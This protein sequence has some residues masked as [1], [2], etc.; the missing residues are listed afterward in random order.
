MVVLSQ[1]C[2]ECHLRQEAL[3]SRSRESVLSPAGAQSGNSVNHF[4]VTDADKVICI[5]KPPS[6][7][8][9][10][11]IMACFPLRNPNDCFDCSLL[12]ITMSLMWSLKS[13]FLPQELTPT[14]VTLGKKNNWQQ[15]FQSIQYFRADVHWEC[16]TGISKA[17]DPGGAPFHRVFGFR[18]GYS[19]LYFTFPVSKE[20]PQFSASRA[21]LLVKHNQDEYLKI[22]T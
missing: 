20:G 6:Y 3:R 15:Y 16:P 8:K 21:C 7:F 2:E 18:G 5:L 10:G 11:V 14:G 4:W 19:V 1:D 13:Q 12:Y 9:L 22:T 17:V